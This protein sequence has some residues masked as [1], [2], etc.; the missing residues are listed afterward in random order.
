MEHEIPEIGSI[1]LTGD[2]G[3]QIV[4][5]PVDMTRIA[6]VDY[7]LASDPAKGEAYIFRMTE[8]GEDVVLDL[9]EDDDEAAYIARVFSEQDEDLDLEI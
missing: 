8:D 5:F 3:S 9:L 6:G 4:V 2:D 7:L 1:T